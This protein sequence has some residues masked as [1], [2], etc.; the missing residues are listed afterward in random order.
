MNDVVLPY[1][2]V[3][4]SA[5][6]KET[7]RGKEATLDTLLAPAFTAP[8]HCHSA[9]FSWPAP[10]VLHWK[11]RVPHLPC[12]GYHWGG[13]LGWPH[14]N[15]LG[16]RGMAGPPPRPQTPAVVSPHPPAR[17]PHRGQTQGPL[18]VGELFPV[19]GSLL[20]EGTSPAAGRGWRGGGAGARWRGAGERWS[21]A[22]GRTLR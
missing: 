14:S 5:L 16:L 17:S 9:V 10:I 6:T 13:Y 11:R 1:N 19:S 22:R 7:R 4:K 8:S 2:S 15:C 20:E 21:A 12:R 18:E 3:F